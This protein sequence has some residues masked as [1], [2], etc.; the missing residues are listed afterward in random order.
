MNLRE[1]VLKNRSYRRFFQDE[2]ISKEQLTAWIDLGR[3]SASGMNVQ[4]LKY[5]LVNDPEICEK[6]F[7]HLAWAGYL[8][9][10][11]GPE[12]G[13]RP[14]AYIILLGDTSIRP[15]FGIDPGIAAQSI[16]LG[17]VESGYGGC[18]IGSIQ[19]E[20]LTESLSIPENFQVL[21]VLALGKPKEEVVLEEM[22]DDSIQYFRDDQMVHHVPKR[23]LK[24]IIIK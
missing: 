3:L 19:R 1:L 15:A 10:W 9:D 14:A 12:I 24:D 17:A 5:K 22:K 11:D 8:K 21:Y 7:I 20:K 4:P 13:E 18:I 16:L 23:A 2:N 6:V